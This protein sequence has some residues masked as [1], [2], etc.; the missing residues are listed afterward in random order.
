VPR[1]HLERN[2]EALG[3]FAA[4]DHSSIVSRIRYP[5]RAYAST[6]AWRASCTAW[7]RVRAPSFSIADPR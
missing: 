1:R 4:G 3:G 2:V 5:N 7:N 6:P